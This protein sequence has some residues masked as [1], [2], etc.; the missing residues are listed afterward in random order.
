MAHNIKKKSQIQ[1][2]RRSRY[3]DILEL[4]NDNEEA[5]KPFPNRDAVFYKASNKGSYFDGRDHLDKLRSEQMKINERVMRD[6][7]LRQY[8]SDNGLTHR[9]LFTQH[10]APTAQGPEHFSI[11]TDE[12]S[13]T[14]EH[15][16][17][18]MEVDSANDVYI[19]ASNAVST[20][21]QL[22]DTNSQ[23]LVQA[24]QQ[25]IAQEQQRSEGVL[26]SLGSGALRVGGN[27]AGNMAGGMDLS[28][29]SVAGLSQEAIQALAG[30]IM[31][32]VSPQQ[33][34]PLSS[35][36]PIPNMQYLTP[37]A[38]LRSHQPNVG[39]TQQALPPTA[40]G[41]QSL[42]PYNP[43][44]QVERRSTA[45]RSFERAKSP[46][47]KA[48]ATPNI[49][50]GGSRM[51]REAAVAASSSSSSMPAL[52][53]TMPQQQQESTETATSPK[54]KK[55]LLKEGAGELKLPQPSKIGIVQ[56]K[57]IFDEANERETIPKST[58]KN[59]TTTYN[60]RVKALAEGDK[61]MAKEI[62]LE[63]Q[64]MYRKRIYSK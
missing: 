60:R 37:T 53:P 61:V 42:P 15:Y 44:E 64:D 27:I 21:E 7:L 58:Y 4:V 22:R 63:L 28:T 46:E 55:T 38:N 17:G 57:R 24:H 40:L 29:A 25:Q 10:D 19:Q 23:Q 8:A 36:D 41:A 32:R 43:T 2:H 5:L 56:L 9:A 50:V 1:F 14:I 31:R 16:G 35:T 47:K 51:P 30:A 54:V 49:Q 48:R 3:E 18:D 59:F 62:L 12:E 11:A 33:D 13:G 45:R 34:Q 39:A 20:A 52:P 6:G 26:R